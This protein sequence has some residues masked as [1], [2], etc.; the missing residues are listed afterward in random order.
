VG[1]A[2]GTGSYAEEFGYDPETGH[3]A[4][5]REVGGPVSNWTYD[6]AG[7]RDD[8]TVDALNRMTASPGRTHRNDL[9]GNRT[10]TDFEQPATVR[11]Y[12]WDDAGRLRACRGTAVG[13]AY[14]YRAD[15]M[16]V[17]KVE[18]V[19]IAAIL[20]DNENVSGYHDFFPMDKPTT[21][22]YHDGQAPMEEDHTVEGQPGHS[23][24]LTVTRS[25][26]GARGTDARYVSLNGAAETAS[27]PIYDG[28]GSMVG[29]V[30]RTE[31]AP[32]FSLGSMRKY[33][34]WGQAR[35]G[36][37]PDQGYCANLG[38]RRDAESGLVYMRARYYEPWTGRFVSEDPARDGQNWYVYCANDPVNK[39][40]PDGTT[41]RGKH[42]GMMINIA[43]AMNSGDFKTVVLMLE[44]LT[45]VEIPME[46]VNILET[47]SDLRKGEL[48]SSMSRTKGAEESM[49]RIIEHIKK[50]DSAKASGQGL[51]T[52]PHWLK[53][54]NN[55]WGDWQKKLRIK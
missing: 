6:A 3:L 50:I 17:R 43:K 19:L 20:D 38:H 23:A 11:K 27:Y 7:N 10:Y 55:F 21:R 18:N 16:R 39:V 5:F 40:D 1:A 34:A 48:G 15:G 30:A 24:Q 41:T 54:I 51:E 13:A 12:D 47:A 37:G 2:F 32:W 25:A 49:D 9:L 22:Y 31:S 42:L 33:D 29:E 26:L 52:I 36:S 45:G 35:S 14:S 44:L 28:H 8:A 4:S 53:E 46:V